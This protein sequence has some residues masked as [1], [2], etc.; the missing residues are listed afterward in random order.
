MSGRIISGAR[1]EV[2]IA[3]TPLNHLPLNGRPTFDGLAADADTAPII[4]IEDG[5][6]VL[7]TDDRD[8]AVAYRDA[9]Q[10][11][12]DNLDARTKADELRRTEPDPARPRL[13][14]TSRE[15]AEGGAS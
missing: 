14:K 1:A 5:A 6:L 15:H 4:T 7:T 3:G 10:Q 12:I 2:S 9:W 11:A 8:V 13:G